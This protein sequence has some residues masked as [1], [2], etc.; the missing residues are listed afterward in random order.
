MGKIFY[1]MGKSS[2]GKDT[3]FKELRE[4]GKL[5]AIV[6]YTTRPIR[7]GERDG[8]EYHFTD[9]DGFQRL[10]SSGKVIEQREYHT[11]CG[12]WRY[13]TVDDGQF[14]PEGAQD[15]IMIGTLEAY[16]NMQAHFGAEKVL[17]VLI[18]LD[19]GE[20]LQRALDREREQERPQY[21]EMC[22][23]FLADGEDFSEEKIREAGIEIRF[24]NNDLK[25]CLERIGV[26]IAENKENG[27]A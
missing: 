26:Y 2:S 7:A 15:Y 18:E 25:R 12:V 23:R 4:A 27:S 3:I 11:F 13:F 14:V 10:S 17:P 5:R 22:R 20:R 19:D 16:R 21:E 9:E 1:L 24:H 8:V 6:P